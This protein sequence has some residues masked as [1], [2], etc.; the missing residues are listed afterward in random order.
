MISYEILGSS[1]RTTQLTFI[2]ANA[3]HDIPNVVVSI[4]C[5]KV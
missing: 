1:N 4:K 3:S 2:F 5:G